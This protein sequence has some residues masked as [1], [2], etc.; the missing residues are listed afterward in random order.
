[1]AEKFGLSEYL[2]ATTKEKA[3]E[4]MFDKFAGIFHAFGRLKSHIIDAIE[5]ERFNEAKYRLFGEKYDSLPTLI[6]KILEDKSSDQVNKYLTLLCAQQLV[7]QLE[8]D[9]KHFKF[10]KDNLE[11]F[12]MIKKKLQVINEIRDS[13]EFDGIE[14]REKFFDWF[15]E[16]FMME[17]PVPEE[18]K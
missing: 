12:K 2:S 11:D 5:N 17:I 10:K 4:S 1:V 8:R 18:S 7:T 6:D 3:P 14:E 16:M 13:F 9:E 15:E